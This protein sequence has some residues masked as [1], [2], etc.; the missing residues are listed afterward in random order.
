[1]FIIDIEERFNQPNTAL[2]VD[3]TAVRKRPSAGEEEVEITESMIK[4]AL[5]QALGIG[6]KL[7]GGQRYVRVE[8]LDA[9]MANWVATARAKFRSADME[10]EA[11]PRR[12][13][14]NGAICYAN[15]FMELSQLIESRS[16]SL[17]LEFQVL[18]QDTERP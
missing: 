18:E 3:V 16:Y 14:V 6:A 12:F 7:N 10:P 4:Y 1:M 8:D 9:L 17:D 2:R 13:I 15:C 5:E 11:F